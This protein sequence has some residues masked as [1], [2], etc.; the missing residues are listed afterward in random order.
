MERRF[1]HDFGDVRVHADACADAA[2]RTLDAD[3]FTSGRH[4]VFAA[5]RYR[6]G[7]EDDR[8]LIAHELVHTLQQGRGVTA[9]SPL[10]SLQAVP[11][12]DPLEQEAA[13]VAGRIAAGQPVP[14]GAVTVAAPDARG[15]IARK[16]RTARER[17]PAEVPDS[18]EAVRALANDIA[19]LFVYDPGDAFGRVKRRLAQLAPATRA[20]IATELGGRIPSIAA[21]RLREIVTELLPPG[22]AAPVTDPAEPAGATE[23]VEAVGHS[24]T[25]EASASAEPAAVAA[26]ADPAAVA[27]GEVPT[28]VEPSPAEVEPAAAPEVPAPATEPEGPVAEPEM[29][30]EVVAADPDAGPVAVAEPDG[31]RRAEASRLPPAPRTAE[32]AGPEE[33]AANSAPGDDTEQEALEAQDE[34]EAEDADQT[35]DGAAGTA[36]TAPDTAPEGAAPP[37]GAGPPEDA[38]AASTASEIADEAATSDAGATSTEA[39]AAT[40]EAGEPLDDSAAA[41]GGEPPSPEQEPELGEL[42]EEE[43]ETEEEAVV[44]PPTTEM[45][46][47]DTEPQ[48]TEPEGAEQLETG[49][50]AEPEQPADPTLAEE[51]P[52]AD[53]AAPVVPGGVEGG[54]A[55]IDEPVEPGT[56]DLSAAD[57][58]GAME[59]A[60]TLPPAQSEA[61]LTGVD[62]AAS[63]SVG[64]QRSALADQPPELDR[65]TGAP[66]V[67][68][69]AAE[70]EEPA[71]PAV[72]PER[73]EPAAEPSAPAPTRI[74]PLP[75]A[76]PPVAA[77]APAPQIAGGAQGEL[78]ADGR[79]ALQAS[80]GA[81]PVHDP[82]LDIGAGPA[83]AV[84]LVGAADPQRALDERQKLETVAR[85]SLA[86]GRRAILRPAGEQHVVPDV[87]PERLRAVITP[88]AVAPPAAPTAAGMTL[89]AADPASIIARQ[90]RGAELRAAAKDAAAG[91]RAR[92][93]EHAAT[94]T[95]ER[96]RSQEH[97]TDLVRESATQQSER[98]AAARGEVHDQRQRWSAAEHQLAEGKLAEAD[99]RVKSGV[100]EVARLKTDAEEKAAGHLETGERE[101]EQARR[102]GEE[103]AAA[104]RRRGLE[105]SSGPLGWLADQATALFDEIKAGITKVFE[106][107]RAA[108]RAAIEQAQRLAAAAIDLARD[109]IVGAINLAGAALIAIGDKL[110]ADFPG[111]R[112]RFRHAI[113]D[114]VAKAKAAVN[115][116]AE[117]LKNV[118]QKALD[119]LGA[120]LDAA[121]GLLEQGLLLIVAGYRA[122]VA[123]ALKWADG[124]VKALGVFAVLV[125]DVA[126]NPKQW[127]INLAA[128]ADDG[129]RNHLWKAFKA[130]VKRWFWEKVE[131][132]L[133]LGLSIWNLLKK[134]GVSLAR[135]GTMAWDAIKAAIPPTLIQILIEKLISLLIPAAAA[136]MLI[137]ETLQAAWGT[138]QRVLEA[139]ERFFAFL[140]AVRTGRAGPKFASAIAAAAVAVIDFVANWLL[141]RLRKPAG[142][143][144]KKLREIAKK[145]GR[146]LRKAAKK[147]G[148]KLF[149]KRKTPKKLTSKRSTKPK[150]DKRA[151]AER[152]VTAATEFLG[153]QL[154]RGMPRP[155]LW[156]QMHY[157]R[158]RW[159]VRIR[160]RDG[161]DTATLSV[162]ANPSRKLPLVK[163]PKAGD[164]PV[165]AYRKRAEELLKWISEHHDIHH[166]LPKT[167]RISKWWRALDIDFN[168]PTVMLELPPFLHQAGVHRSFRQLK[169]E[170][171]IKGHG[172]T[173]KG[174]RDAWGAEWWRWVQTHLRAN[175]IT[176]T[177]EVRG[178]SETFKRRLRD[179][180]NRRI[181]FMLGFFSGWLQYDLHKF[182]I[183]KGGGA[184]YRN[185]YR[186]KLESFVKRLRKHNRKKP[187][188]TRKAISKWLK[189]QPLGAELTKK[190]ADALYD[191]WKARR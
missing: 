152:R 176:S 151:N 91:M 110:L 35:L 17:I 29:D 53:E 102:E 89:A 78:S 181:D 49:S 109:T 50:E 116:L 97:V 136:V 111:V 117:G 129:V 139:F 177:V 94:A 65:P 84:T 9:V 15:R 12:S 95:A 67:E 80:L 72:A 4:I 51:E 98:R 23:P 48:A 148:S 137:I 189:G 125:K 147:I 185:K 134:G 126:A 81:L 44:E 63:R 155:I 47:E 119:A 71:E 149:G 28:A 142:K 190:Q 124:L 40:R 113:E 42:P 143:I 77:R 145:L 82:A 5:G 170:L 24:A 159:R 3:A 186:K 31:D 118:V 166:I 133:G 158:A 30:A 73:L 146:R 86:E 161:D 56:P 120:A 183:S 76:P 187:W 90:Q 153:R 1:G 27:D 21:T 172:R 179:D 20:A 18:P 52:T 60:G 13:N 171:G 168:D 141:K 8:W 188:R 122:V 178:S 131:E 46:G 19:V 88:A 191:Y 164:P 85:D 61:A 58:A 175:N 157:A 106:V 6:P 130:A 105:K 22:A 10:A 41:A 38:A 163:K 43:P 92:R 154:I 140:K 123:G 138:I 93:A 101:A 182:R 87:P 16:A 59:T 36:G 39:M 25:T 144:A 11:D 107:A 127:I 103:Q 68:E 26:P 64:A 83:P 174:L 165:E 37:E 34:A 96:Q 74:T 162:E 32:A 169:V 70:N 156:A 173:V 115:A 62:A 66:T 112:D 57:P 100:E 184:P 135:I 167:S 150:P 79:K 121:L 7:G 75:P 69:L 14:P 99:T 45:A 114:R 180:I 54:A 108:V 33:D 128:S 160:L 2:A 132:V 104:E 55:P